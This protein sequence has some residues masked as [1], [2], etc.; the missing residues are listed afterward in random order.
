VIN[1]AGSLS[2]CSHLRPIFA[3]NTTG[4][5]GWSG[6][7]ARAVPRLGARGAGKPPVCFGRGA[8]QPRASRWCLRG[9]RLSVALHRPGIRS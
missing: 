4:L 8:R 7:A 5:V 3:K 2:P 9:C 1:L 6:P